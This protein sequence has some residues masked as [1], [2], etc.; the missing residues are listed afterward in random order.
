MIFIPSGRRREPANSVRVLQVIFYGKKC[1][2]V[3]ILCVAYIEARIHVAVSKLMTLYHIAR[4]LTTFTL[5]LVE[6]F[7]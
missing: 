1:V 4:W 7:Q 2:L 6:A 3:W 5:S